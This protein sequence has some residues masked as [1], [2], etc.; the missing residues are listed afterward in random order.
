MRHTQTNTSSPRTASYPGEGRLDNFDCELPDDIRAEL[1]GRN[2]RSNPPHI[3][4]RQ[5]PVRIRPSW[6]RG[7]LIFAG[8]VCLPFAAI[9]IAAGLLVML[10]GIPTPVARPTIATP[11]PMVQMTPSLPTPE[12]R[13]AELVPVTVK[14]AEQVLRIGRWNQVWMPD[15]L[16]WIRFRGIRETFEQL[17]TDPQIGDAYG[18]NTGQHALWVWCVPAGFTRP[19][20]QDP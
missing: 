1:T 9:A 2:E 8:I 6:H 20:W 5:A 18:V 14:R 12:V 3:E 17:P 15:G 11:T 10:T 4:Q 13:R 19:V 16:M 7:L